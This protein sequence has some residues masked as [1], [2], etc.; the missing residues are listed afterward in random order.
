MYFL[1]PNVIRGT[2]GIVHPRMEV[3]PSFT[4]PLLQSHIQQQKTTISR[5]LQNDGNKEQFKVTIGQKSTT[6]YDLCCV[7][8][9]LRNFDAQDFQRCCQEHRNTGMGRHED[10]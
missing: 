4:H 7:V 1:Y 10:E 6:R 9:L 3:L 2:K 5:N 8:K